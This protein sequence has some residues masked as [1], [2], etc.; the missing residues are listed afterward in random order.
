MA[1]HL[2]WER[3]G[4]GEPLL[5][6]HGLGAT[7][8]DF[9]GLRRHLESEYRVLAPDLP[10]TGASP[11]LRE[12]PTVGA[13]AEVLAADLDHL[14]VRRAH[15]LG[16]SL[17]ARIGLE[18]ARRGRARSLVAIAPSGVS[19][20]PERLYQ[21]AVTGAARVLLRRLRPVLGF[22]A[23]SPWG[24]VG[25]LGWLRSQ[26]WRASE[27]E[28]RAVGVGFAE[29]EDF[30]RLLWSAVLVDVPAGLERVNCPVMLAQGTADLL[31]G[32]Q[33][34]R[35]LLAVP[36]ARFTP[37]LGAGHTPQSDTPQTILWL[38]REA[39]RRA[40]AGEDP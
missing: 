2:S 3:A 8:D 19:L 39:T 33:T 34:L 29:S 26:P 7:R 1:T 9:S 30:W 6:L 36:G 28:A 10:G 37:L 35:Y 11:A 31:T 15:V 25:L 24:R 40:G 23:R 16:V 12:R 5:L 21:G 4:S 38:V 20:P 17:G 27:T 14:G 32:G 18:L 13:L 22:L